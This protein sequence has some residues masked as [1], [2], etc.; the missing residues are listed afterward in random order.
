[1]GTGRG[2]TQGAGQRGEAKGGWGAGGESWGAGAC[3]PKFP[4]AA[5][6]PLTL[7]DREERRRLL[8][9]AAC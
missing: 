1:M 2:W 5:G 6:L 3:L 4:E 9:G 8:W 7:L